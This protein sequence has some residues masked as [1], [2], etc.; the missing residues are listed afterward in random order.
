MEANLVS[1]CTSNEYHPLKV[2]LTKQVIIQIDW[3]KELH[4]FEVY[5]NHICVGGGLTISQLKVHLHHAI[6]TLPGIKF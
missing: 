1:G 3:M 2:H 5:E 4:S 6:K